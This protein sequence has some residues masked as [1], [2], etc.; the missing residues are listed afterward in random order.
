[1]KFDLSLFKTIL[2]SLGVVS[3]VIGVYQTI[4]LQN[5]QA[6]YWIFMV[7]MCCWLPLRYWRQKEAAEAKAAAQAAATRPSSAVEPP[8]GGRKP[9][10]KRR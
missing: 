10:R 7:S 9:G 8:R 5:L 4:I 2:F 6:N 1:M 3:F